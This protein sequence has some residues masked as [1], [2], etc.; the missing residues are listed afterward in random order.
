ML[1]NLDIDDLM[2]ESYWGKMVIQLVTIVTV[3]L[4]NCPVS[5]VIDKS[6]IFHLDIVEVCYI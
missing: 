4:I 6:E 1:N 3:K 5:P 2:V